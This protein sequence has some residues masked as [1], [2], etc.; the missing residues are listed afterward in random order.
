[1]TANQN[2][3]RKMN[4]SKK[5]VQPPS[6]NQNELKPQPPVEEESKN[7]QDTFAELE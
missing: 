5:P 3:Q 1:M 4:R 2:A 6:K 7:V